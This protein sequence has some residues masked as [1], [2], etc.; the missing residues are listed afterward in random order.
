ME[1]INLSEKLA[2]L[3]SDK[4]IDIVRNY[5]QYGYTDEIRSMA[6]S[7]LEKQGIS[8]EDLRLTGNLENATFNQASDL[9]SSF[10]R[11]STIAFIAYCL[12]IAV[13]GL[14]IYHVLANNTVTTAVFLLLVIVYI[15]FLTRSFINQNNFFKLAGA[16]YGS[17]G[18]LVYLLLGM[19]F[20]IFM[21]FLFRKQMKERMSF[22]E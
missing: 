16:D 22:I 21:Y 20:Y 19:P 12:A 11:N 15:I 8:T 13:K 9:F 5:K 4:L 14:L 10:N 2:K 1:T 6:L 7:Q 18:A 17:E 3:D